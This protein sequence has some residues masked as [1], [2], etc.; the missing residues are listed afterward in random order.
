VKGSILH[1][2]T[3]SRS[4]A[5]PSGP[6]ELAAYSLEPEVPLFTQFPTN[7]LLGNSEGIKRAGAAAM[8][9]SS[10]F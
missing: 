2:S 3:E 6:Q 9:S 1:Y 5:K 7:G 10:C 8:L 4:T